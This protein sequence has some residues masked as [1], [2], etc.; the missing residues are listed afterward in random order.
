PQVSERILQEALRLLT[1]G[2]E[3]LILDGSQATLRQATWLM[4]IF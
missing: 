4:D 1:S 2:G 3:V